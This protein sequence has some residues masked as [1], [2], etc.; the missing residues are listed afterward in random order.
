[1]LD[2]PLAKIRM[3]G[4]LFYRW[5]FHGFLHWGYNYWYKSQTRTRIDPFNVQ[6]GLMWPG[7]AYGDTFMVYPGADG[8]I[9][10]LRWEVF[11]DSMQDYALLQTLGVERDAKLLRDLKTFEDFPKSADWL[12]RTRRKLLTAAAKV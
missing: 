5:P 12:A 3:N 8:P 6:D 1:L 7:W 9:D 2:T 4:W 10:S 11:A